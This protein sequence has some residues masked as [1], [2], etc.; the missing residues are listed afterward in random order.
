MQVVVNVS[1]ARTNDSVQDV[2]VTYSLGSCIGVALYDPVAKVAGLL[3]FQLPTSTLN[4]EQARL[5][6]CMFADTGMKTLLSEMESRGGVRKRMKAK[7]AGAAQMLNDAAMFNIGKKNHAAI[8]KIFWQFGMF[9][10][11]EEIGG[12]APRTMYLQAA[13]GMVTIKSRQET[14]EL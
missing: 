1:D 3:H 5:N 7:L 8:R 9:I 14:R 4:P 13:D 10:E 2:L 12:E 11:A 6:P